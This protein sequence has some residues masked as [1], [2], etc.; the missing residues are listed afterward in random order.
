MPL[1]E[2]IAV[3]LS[4]CTVADWQSIDEQLMRLKQKDFGENTIRL[5]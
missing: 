3:S 5:A 1:L 2:L 4:R